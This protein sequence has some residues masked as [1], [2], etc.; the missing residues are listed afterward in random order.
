MQNSE[1]SGM[2]KQLLLT[3]RVLLR[4]TAAKAGKLEQPQRL[5]ARR[6]ANLPMTMAGGTANHPDNYSTHTL[7]FLRFLG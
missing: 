3:L 1:R 2:L 5:E 7:H 4:R 6:A